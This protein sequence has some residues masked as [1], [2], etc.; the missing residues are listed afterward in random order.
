[1][2]SRC[3][4]RR[5]DCRF[6]RRC[7]F[8]SAR[9]CVFLSFSDSIR[10]ARCMG[11]TCTPTV[12]PAARPPHP[13]LRARHRPSFA[14]V[15]GRAARIAARAVQ[16]RGYPAS[17]ALARLGV[18]EPRGRRRR[19]MCWVIPVAHFG[20]GCAYRSFFQSG[21]RNTGLSGSQDFP[22]PQA[23]SCRPRCIGLPECTQHRSL[24]GRV[25]MHEH[26]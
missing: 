10:S 5:N 26:S 6:L 3:A 24:K 17:L 1:M 21:N 2:P 4:P 23:H 11:R 22:R 18:D 15:S 13:A 19:A 20:Y 7:R 14:P 12:Q 9:S 25:Q 16:L 8:P